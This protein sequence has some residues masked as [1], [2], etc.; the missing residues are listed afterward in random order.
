MGRFA[1][2]FLWQV[3][4][5]EEGRTQVCY[6]YTATREDPVMGSEYQPALTGAWE[7]AEIGRPGALTFG[8]N[9]LRGIYAGLGNCV[10]RGSGGCEPGSEVPGVVER[11]E[12][13]RDRLGRWLKHNRL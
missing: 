5:E 10:A 11:A 2:N 4:I 13:N 1:G 6:K 3:R 7:I 9:G 8:V 12:R